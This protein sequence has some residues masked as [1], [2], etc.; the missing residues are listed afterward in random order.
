M[1]G[2]KTCGLGVRHTCRRLDVTMDVTVEFAMMEF[3]LVEFAVVEF[4]A[5][6]AAAATVAA[7]LSDCGATAASISVCCSVC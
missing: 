4:V 7:G 2:R 1:H 3:A 5:A 6:A